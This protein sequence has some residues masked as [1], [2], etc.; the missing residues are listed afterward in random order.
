[1]SEVFLCQ[2]GQLTG[3]S[4]SALRKAG[5][6]VVEVEDPSKCQFI[7]AGETIP[8]SDMLWA[9]VEALCFGTEYT[10]SSQARERLSYNLLK[11]IND[12]R[13]PQRIAN[14]A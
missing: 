7:R 14:T 9:A 6:V 11:I 10:K 13:A 3:P 2:T 4:K 1:M 12:Q 5:V 8:T